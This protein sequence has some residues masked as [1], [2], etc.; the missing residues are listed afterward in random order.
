MLQLL[1]EFA[2]LFSVVALLHGL[3]LLHLSNSGE[4]TLLTRDRRNATCPA[5]VAGVMHEFLHAMSRAFH[6][7][8]AELKQQ[9]RALRPLL[10]EVR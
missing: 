1:P 6:H 7:V 5:A 10:V 8:H 9:Q 2:R 4:E 3:K